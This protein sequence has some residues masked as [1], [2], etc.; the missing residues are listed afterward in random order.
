M[1]ALGDLALIL[2]GSGC[3]GVGAI[4]G[5]VGIWGLTSGWF[6]GQWALPIVLVMCAFALIF[7]LGGG[8]AVL[9]GL[10]VIRSE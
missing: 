5:W 2:F 9:V 1:R 8:K 7:I 4:L 6:D 10:R 3:V